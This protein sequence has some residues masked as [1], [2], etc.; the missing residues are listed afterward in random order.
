M[1]RPNLKIAYNTSENDIRTEFYLPCLKWAL[2]FERGVGYF[3]SGWLE[4]N[5]KGMAEFISHGG[6][7]RWITSPILSEKDME[8]FVNIANGQQEAYL[9]KLINFDVEKLEYEMRQDVR[10]LLAWMIHD[11]VLEM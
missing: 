2:Q 1:N 5:A 6:K 7:A 10:N 4:Y 8:I 11:G 3:T 9:E